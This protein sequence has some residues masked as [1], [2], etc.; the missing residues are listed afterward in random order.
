MTDQDSLG[1]MTKDRGS[2]TG[3]EVQKKKKKKN[4]SD[5]SRVGL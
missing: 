3:R 5:V 2:R 1:K 4:L